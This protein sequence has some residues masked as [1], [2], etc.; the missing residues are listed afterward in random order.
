[1]LNRLEHSRLEQ[2]GVQK[3]GRW[4]RS[5]GRQQSAGLQARGARG[6]PTTAPG[7][8]PQGAG[9]VHSRT[10]SRCCQWA[11]AGATHQNPRAATDSD[12][13]QPGSAPRE[14]TPGIPWEVSEAQWLCV[15]LFWG[16]GGDAGG[17]KSKGMMQ[18]H[19]VQLI[20]GSGSVFIFVFLSSQFL[21]NNLKI[22]K[23]KIP[24]YESRELGNKPQ[25]KIKYFCMSSLSCDCTYQ[26]PTL[27]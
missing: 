11:R 1:M 7:S 3:S 14:H 22:E 21:P 19:K 12:A 15:N 8:R 20:W 2:A 10:P 4:G 17:L 6:P 18:G 26:A 27:T 25:G 5:P 9:A 16:W 24:V 13:Q 23:K